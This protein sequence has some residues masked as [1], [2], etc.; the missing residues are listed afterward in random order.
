MEA[1]N[2]SAEI[3]STEFFSMTDLEET[4]ISVLAAAEEQIKLMCGG[5]LQRITLIH[6]QQLAKY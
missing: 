5:C 3:K 6:K 4:N 2:S 1:K